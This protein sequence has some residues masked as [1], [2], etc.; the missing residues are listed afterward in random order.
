MSVNFRKIIPTSKIQTKCAMLHGRML[1]TFS[2]GVLMFNLFIFIIYF[3]NFNKL[4][5]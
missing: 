4:V 3:I 1:F 2:V 5:L